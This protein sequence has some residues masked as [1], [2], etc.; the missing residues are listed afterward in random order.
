MSR[1]KLTSVYAAAVLFLYLLFIGAAASSLFLGIKVQN[2]LRARSEYSFDDGIIPAFISQ[3]LR[4]SDGVGTIY[5]GDFDG[6]SALYIE[7]FLNRA[8][9]TDIIYSYDGQL[10]EL[11]CEKGARFTCDGGIRLA[12]LNQVAFSESRSGLI[13]ADITGSDGK[14]RALCVFLRRGGGI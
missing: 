2:S 11:F 3:K 10:Y 9:Y 12:P 1:T 4:E 8:I 13:Q 7:S 14:T 6:S 5:I